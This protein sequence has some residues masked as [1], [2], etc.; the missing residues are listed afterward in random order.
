MQT[1]TRPG[2]I[3]DVRG[4][5]MLRRPY[6]LFLGDATDDLAAKTAR[7]VSA[8]RP[9]WCV[10]QLRLD[11]CATSVDLEDMTIE[12]AVAAG[13][14]TLLIGVANRGGVIAESW[15]PTLHQ[16][17]AAGLDG[18]RR[19]VNRAAL[20]RRARRAD[21]RGRAQRE[22]HRRRPSQRRRRERGEVGSGP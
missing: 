14:K 16:A 4:A 11:G 20:G 18:V 1:I 7:G 21:R 5:I 15:R 10:G 22:P 8:W 9:Q 19:G 3:A 17:A 13:A 12:Q 2:D 6:L